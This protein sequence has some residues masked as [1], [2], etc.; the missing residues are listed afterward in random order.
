MLKKDENLDRLQ[1]DLQASAKE[2]TTI[3]GVLA[4]VSQERDMMWEEVK[5]Y[6]EQDM[7]LNS[8]IN[9]LKK[10]IEALDEDSLLKEGQITIL[11]DTLGN[12]P[13]DLLGS[14]NCT[15]EFLLE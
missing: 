2:L 9:V 13:F 10:K 6:K 12:R 8:E 4:K 7:L 5:Q 3:R 15:R 1:S 14:P 11:K